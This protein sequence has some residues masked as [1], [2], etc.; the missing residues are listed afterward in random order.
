MKTLHFT[1]TLNHAP[2]IVYEALTRPAVLNLWLSNGN[3]INLNVGNCYFLEWNS[4]YFAAGEYTALEP[5]KHLAFT[6]LGKD[7][8][9]KTEVS[10]TLTPEGEGTRLDLEHSG[11]GA[12]AEWAAAAKQLADGW[13]QGLADLKYT[14]DTG[15]DARLMRRPMLGIYPSNLDEAAAQRLGLPITEGLLLNNVVPGMGAEQAGLQMHDVIVSVNGQPT[16]DFSA[17]NRVITPFRAGQVVS[18]EYYRGSEKH[19]LQMTLSERPK[20]E[21]PA[22]VAEVATN[23]KE[24]NT[25]ALTGL[26]ELLQGVPET[27]LV[28][29]P[30][31]EE[32]SVNDVLAHL[33]WAEKHQQILLWAMYG[34]E[35]YVPWTGNNAVQLAGILAVY[36][37]SGELLAELERSLRATEAMVAAIDESFTA[38]KAEYGIIAAN[39]NASQQH[40]QSH[41]D[42]IR[43]AIQ[44]AT[45][46]VPA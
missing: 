24:A 34:G 26:R 18:L 40:I 43:N 41:F 8:P 37:T 35:D 28:Q 36:P 17:F 27:A 23:F 39:A 31:P 16:P 10:I 3:R 22:T 14:L 4:G 12:G 21:V 5:G 6:W 33:I 29:R 7:E 19:A 42:Q 15:L 45:V 2:S 30:A 1:E 32:W 9:A 46:A 11:I 20:P 38:Y 25:T 44:A 13:R